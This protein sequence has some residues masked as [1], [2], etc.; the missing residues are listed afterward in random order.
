MTLTTDLQHLRSTTTKVLVPAL[1]V[2]VPLI[3][4]TAWASGKPY[5]LWFALAAVMVAGVAAMQGAGGRA[6]D[7]ATRLTV[8]VAYVAMVSLLLAACAGGTYQT[9]LHMYYFAAIAIV[10]AYCDWQ[11][12]LAAAGATAMHHLVLNFL[13]PLL[14]FPGGGDILR[15]L[16]HAV[17]VVLE[18]GVLVWLTTQIETLSTRSASSL[19]EAEAAR[20][21]MQEAQR[22]QARVAGRA[23][24]TRRETLLDVAN[25]LEQELRGALDGVAA[26]TA[27]LKHGAS[28]MLTNAAKSDAVSQTVAGSVTTT[29]AEVQSISA[30]IEE[31]AATALELARQIASA[32]ATARQADDRAA[33]TAKTMQMLSQEADRIGDVVTL[34][35]DIASRTNLLALN[36]TIEAARAG[37]AGKGFTVVASEVKNL[38]VQTS[39]ATDQIQGLIE[40]L[41][42]SAAD[43]VRTIEDIKATLGDIS[44]ASTVVAGAVEQQQA[45]TAEISRNVAAASHGIHAISDS[46]REASKLATDTRGA[47]SEIEAAIDSVDHGAAHLSSAI[48]DLLGKLRAA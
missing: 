25:R 2:H 19:A 11:V 45:A 36:A 31:L 46:V 40:A 16:L 26:N 6:A 20:D 10:A 15:V 22:E 21:A 5:W 42:A 28:R 8:S 43:S 17:I 30:A 34:I 3:A 41:R 44:R 12:I 39:R 33:E 37:E 24:A 18:A 23:E 27:G 47:A 13:A 14:V 9:D 4:G 38:A 1:W 32:A 7:R 35:T 29:S 48:H